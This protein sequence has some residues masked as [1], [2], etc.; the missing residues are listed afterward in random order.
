VTVGKQ[1]TVICISD[2]KTGFGL[3][4][5]FTGCSQVE[6]TKNDNTLK[7]TVIIAYEYKIKSSTSV[8]SPNY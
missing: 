1:N 7:I 5:R 3:M 6:T 8:N 4:N 2:L